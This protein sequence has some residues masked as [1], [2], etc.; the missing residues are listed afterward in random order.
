MHGGGVCKVSFKVSGVFLH[1]VCGADVFRV[2]LCPFDAVLIFDLSTFWGLT[3]VCFFI[4]PVTVGHREECW[5]A[6]SFNRII[7]A[8]TSSRGCFSFVWWLRPQTKKPLSP[9]IQSLA[10]AFRYFG[11]DRLVWVRIYSFFFAPYRRIA[12]RASSGLNLVG[13]STVV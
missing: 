8:V 7:A 13:L 12:V 11:L 3:V 5:G 9:L 2:F 1:D 4:D 10:V 6:F